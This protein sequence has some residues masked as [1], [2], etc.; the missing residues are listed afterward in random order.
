MK[1]KGLFMGMLLM[2]LVCGFMLVGCGSKCVSDGN[3]TG[4]ESSPT[5]SGWYLGCNMTSCAVMKGVNTG[6]VG[7]GRKLSCDCN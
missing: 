5:T 4:Q 1:K 7:S 6:S 3:C 2:V